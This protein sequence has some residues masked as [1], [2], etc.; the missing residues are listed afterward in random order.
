VSAFCLVAP[1]A[2]CSPKVVHVSGHWSLL[3]W[4]HGELKIETSHNP[5]E[6]Y[7]GNTNYYFHYSDDKGD[8]VGTCDGLDYF[9]VNYFFPVADADKTNASTSHYMGLGEI[10][11]LSFPSNAM[12]VLQSLWLALYWPFHTNEFP[13]GDCPIELWPKKGPWKRYE[14]S[15]EMQ[16][17]GGAPGLRRVNFYLLMPPPTQEDKWLSSALNV[18]DCT[19][20]NG[21]AFPTHF[22]FSDNMQKGSPTNNDDVLIIQ[23]YDFLVDKISVEKKLPSIF[24][25]IFRGKVVGLHDFRPSEKD[26]P[27]YRGGYQY[28]VGGP[29][30]PDM[31]LNGTFVSRNTREYQLLMAGE[32]ERLHLTGPN[33]TRHALAVRLVIFFS[34]GLAIFFGVGFYLL[35]QARKSKGNRAAQ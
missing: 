18:V 6:A 25:P 3:R 34:L 31:P 14:M 9:W 2:L 12:P 19:N 29:Y 8:W 20:V 28:I 30:P 27:Q 22:Q 35:Y 33:G 26:G 7:I 4:S 15:A 17:C 5:F 11:R 13:T 24:P 16:I 23:Q 10:G 32:W 21:R 1:V